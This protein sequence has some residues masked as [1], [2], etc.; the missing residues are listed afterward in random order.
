MLKSDL[1]P[2]ICKLYFIMLTLLTLLHLN[3]FTYIYSIEL[4]APMQQKKKMKKKCI[5]FYIKEKQIWKN[6]CLTQTELNFFF[7]KI[8]RLLFYHIQKKIFINFSIH[9]KFIFLSWHYS[10]S[11]IYCI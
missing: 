5:S 1:N 4:L 3:L 11:F 10:K 6:E 8:K 7:I 9:L 2:Y